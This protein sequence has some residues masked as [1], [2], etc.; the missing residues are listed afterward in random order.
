MKRGLISYIISFL[1]AKRSDSHPQLENDDNALSRNGSTFNLDPRESDEGDALFGVNSLLR[2]QEQVG[3]EDG[4]RDLREGSRVTKGAAA[5]NG[6]GNVSRISDQRHTIDRSLKVV[7]SVS[8][9]MAYLDRYRL[10]WMIAFFSLPIDFLLVW[11]V[12]FINLTKEEFGSID[13]LMGVSIVIGLSALFKERVIDW[14]V[15]VWVTIDSISEESKKKLAPWFFGA[16]LLYSLLDN[17]LDIGIG[18]WAEF[19]A[20]VVV[21]MLVVPVVY[22]YLE[23]VLA[24]HR[25][26]ISNQ[27]VWLN[28][29]NW[30]IFVALTVMLFATRA[31]S[32]LAVIQ[33]KVGALDFTEY[34]SYSAIAAMLLLPLYPDE[35]LFIVKC[36]RC[37]RSTSRALKGQGFCPYCSRDK[38]QGLGSRA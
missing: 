21:L 37:G 26:E 13:L 9:P 17:F 24:K 34:L 23:S 33:A 32:V 1:T 29:I 6:E 2:G 25:Q 19:V 18:S 10:F 16:L 5:E 12:T 27:L 20:I 38:F 4:Y 31:I 36:R 28:M 15:H 3:G 22:S 14:L 35:S 30:K 8:N 7:D 11:G